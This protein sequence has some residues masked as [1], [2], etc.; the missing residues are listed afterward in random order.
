MERDHAYYEAYREFHKNVQVLY[1]RWKQPIEDAARSQGIEI[2]CKQTLLKLY[3]ARFGAPAAEVRAALDATHDPATLDDWT[4]LL[5]TRTEAEV[6]V[7]LL[8]H[9]E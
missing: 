6:R 9:P 5:C 3:E 1:E 8:G 7:A 4:V 2:G